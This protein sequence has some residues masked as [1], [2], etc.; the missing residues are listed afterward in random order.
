M[1]ECNLSQYKKIHFIGIKG[2]AMSGLAVICK[3]KGHEVMGSDVENEFITDKVLE[4]KE[5]A[6]FS[7]FHEKNL[8]W[9]PDLIVVGGSWDDTNIEVQEAKK[10]KIRII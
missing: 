9:A 1:K 3:E 4:E 8:I 5:I 6:V 7:G 10:Q 2:G